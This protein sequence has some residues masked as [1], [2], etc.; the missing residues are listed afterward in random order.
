MGIAPTNWDNW[1]LQQHPRSNRGQR[2]RQIAAIE[3]V[4]RWIDDHIQADTVQRAEGFGK[5]H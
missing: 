5:G 4:G 1:W 2:A 3:G